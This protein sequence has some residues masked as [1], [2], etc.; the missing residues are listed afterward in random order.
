MEFK[1]TYLRNRAM[2]IDYLDKMMVEDIMEKYR[3]S[4]AMVSAGMRQALEIIQDYTDYDGGTSLEMTVLQK[5]KH[6]ILHYMKERI[7]TTSLT[8]DAKTILHDTFGEGYGVTIDTHDKR[9]RRE[10]NRR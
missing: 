5:N 6:D 3:V 10:G 4:K 7:P 8:P 2:L 9:I 1:T